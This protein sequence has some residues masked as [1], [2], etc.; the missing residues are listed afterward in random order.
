MSAPFIRSI[1]NEDNEIVRVFV[2]SEYFN[3]IQCHTITNSL[4]SIIEAKI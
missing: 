4:D 1:K 2:V 3:E